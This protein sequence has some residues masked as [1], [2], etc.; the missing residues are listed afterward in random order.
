RHAL[1]PVT[2]DEPRNLPLRDG[3]TYLIIGGARGAGLATAARIA[4]RVSARIILAGRGEHSPEI[5]GAIYERCDIADADAVRA[6]IT[7]IG[8]LNGIV[9]SAL[10]LRDGA[11]ASMTKDDLDAALLPKI[12]GTLNLANAVRGLPLDWV[13]LYSSIM[14]MWG[15]AGQANYAAAS[16]FQ[17]AVASAFAP[18]PVKII[19]W[20]YWGEVGSV[21]AEPYRRRLAASGILPMT[22]AEA[23]DAFERVLASP[24]EQVVVVR[25]TDAG[26]ALLGIAEN[27]SAEAALDAYCA[28]AVASM[29]LQRAEVLP[30]YERLFDALQAIAR[31]AGVPPA[32]AAASRRRDPQ[33][34]L[35]SRCLDALPRVLRGEVPPHQL[36]FPD[37]STRLVE[38]VYR[39]A[40]DA[41]RANDAVAEIVEQLVRERDGHVRI[42]EVGAGTGSTTAAV[43][44][45]LDSHAARIVY[46]FTDVSPHF[47]K[48][49]RERFPQ[50]FMRFEH[51]DV[52]QEIAGA[53]DVIIATNVL[54]ATRRLDAT[55]RNLKNA[56]TPNGALVLNEVTT[57]R[58]F[59]AVTFGL[60]DGWWRF[61]D[62]E[63][64]HPHAPIAGAA[65][66]RTI[67]ADEGFR[68]E[69]VNSVEHQSVFLALA[70]PRVSIDGHAYARR[71]VAEV[72]KIDPMAIEATRPLGDYGIDSIVNIELVA[73]FERDHGPLPSTLLFEHLTLASLGDYFSSR[74]TSVAIETPKREEAREEDIA[75]VGISGR[76][77]MAPDLD[78]FWQNLRAGK[79][80]ATRVSPSRWSA[81][82]GSE[83]WGAF[84]DDADC[85]DPQ[86]FGISPREASRIDPQER[87]MLESAWSAMEDAGYTRASLRE[88]GDV[89]VFVGVMHSSYELVASSLGAPEAAQAAYWSIANRISFTFDLHGPSLAVDTACSSSLAALHLACA[90]IR[91]GESAAAFAGGV[92]LILHPAHLASLAGLN[93]L[94][95]DGRCKSFG[96]GA[97]GFVAGE[98]VGCVLLKPLR[99]AIADGDTIH[100]IIKGSAMNAGG[101]TGG[102]TVPNPNAQS[103]VVERALGAS[104]VAPSTISYVEAHGTGTALGDPI[105]IR[106][107][108][109]AWRDADAKCAVGSVKSNIGHLESAAGIAG[110]LKVVLQMRHG[111]LAPSLHADELNPKLDL[112]ATPFAVQRELAPWNAELRRAGVS[113]F[114]AGGSNVHVVLEE[115]RAHSDATSVESAVPIVLS[116][117]DHAA[118]LRR[119]R[120]LLDRPSLPALNDLAYTLHIGRES[121]HARFA[122]MARSL[123]EL[124]TKLAAFV[125]GTFSGEEVSADPPRGRRV[126]LP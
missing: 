123:D 26:R 115:Y 31:N 56:L 70:S 103:A 111:E 117:R 39:D 112:A 8:P 6:L 52:E 67:L 57:F 62:R 72:L 92:N 18:I 109:K 29:Q 94:S 33:F 105:E 83:A 58:P 74:A 86:L 43:L 82:E 11:L 84:L 80:C 118:L 37:G 119:A 51:V 81:G 108:A 76:F 90:S 5:A 114:G 64:R 46:H 7:R 36:L 27:E 107:L 61:E 14:S 71:V 89:G 66:W 41:K 122:C 87:I 101:R 126:P 40:G 17:D 68:V 10:V 35:A 63:R 73:R 30:K 1:V 77:P 25:A 85:F 34:E 55:L 44:A 79:H 116:A 102:Y 69:R 91:G 65:Q 93:M 32:N 47:L 54:H 113:S 124:R 45:R 22:T 96:T 13:V 48:L 59:H 19:N 120:Q 2:L 125:D 3:G 42:L 53:F 12:D 100:A 88:L 28:N 20:G 4:Q 24:H 49:G 60:L 16:T 9:H 121:M 106:G 23:V 98:G 97:D 75:I 15:N 99:R 104:G 95:E 50:A 38:S 21:A 78:A 110:V